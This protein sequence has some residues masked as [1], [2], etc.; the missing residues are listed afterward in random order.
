MQQAHLI[1]RARRQMKECKRVQQQQQNKRGKHRKAKGNKKNRRGPGD[2]A[3]NGR[4]SEDDDDDRDFGEMIRRVEQSMVRCHLNV[5]SVM[6]CVEGYVCVAVSCELSG[7]KNAG[8][9]IRNLYVAPQHLKIPDDE[10][11]WD[12]AAS[13]VFV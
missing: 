1:E 11:E 9:D 13:H 3:A 8:S 7:A 10:R 6:Q 5:T 2:P 12:A 4:D